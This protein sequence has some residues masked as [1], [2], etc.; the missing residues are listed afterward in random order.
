VTDAQDK[1]VALG[2]AKAD[3]TPSIWA[4]P[5]VPAGDSPPLPMWPLVGGVILWCG[6]IAF[7]VVMMIHRVETAPV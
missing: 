6:W 2:S 4:D 7:L 5:R 3:E 1:T